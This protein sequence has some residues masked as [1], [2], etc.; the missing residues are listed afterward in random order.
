M[1]I[2]VLGCGR[3]GTFHAWYAQKI[4]HEV[5]LWGRKGSSHLQTLS[6]THQNEYLTLPQE[7]VLTDDLVA[8]V[9]HA[10]T[11]IISISSQQLRSFCRQLAGL[12]VNLAKK[13]FV[14]CM[15]GLEIGT[16]KRNQTAGASWPGRCV[17]HP[18]TD[19]EPGCGP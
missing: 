9:S 5:M 19:R 6:A 10:D 4:G 2:S 16:G 3:W 17:H 11:I 14:L 1:K 12:G 15:K 18:C 7:V 13:R 8:A